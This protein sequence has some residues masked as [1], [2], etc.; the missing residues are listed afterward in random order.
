MELKLEVVLS[1]SI[2]RKKP[3][4]RFCWLGQEKESVFLLDDKRISE[5]NMVS[6]RTKKRTPK[7]HSLL[8]SVVKMASSHN[9]MWLCGLLV[10]GELFLWNRDKDLLKT[11]T[12][13]PEI[14]HMINSAQGD[15]LKL[16]LQVSCDGM[17]VLLA[18]ISGQ[19][20]LWECTEGRYFPGLRDGPVKGR[21]A[22]LLPLEETILPSTKDKEASQHTIFVNTEVMADICLSAF[23]FTSGKQLVVT[24]LKIQWSQGSVRIGSVGYNI[25]WSTKKYPMSHLCPPCQPVKSR[26]AL[27]P[28]F[29]PDGRLLAIVLNQRK[30]KDTQ[31]LFVSTQNFVSVS[32]DLGGCG[33]KKMDIPS[34]YVRSYWVGSVS[35]S[36]EGLFFACVLKRGS[37]LMLARLG[38]LLTLTSSGCN[39]DFGPAQFLPL[40]PLVTYR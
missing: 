5:I 12:G 39:V 31:V 6:G 32:S 21:W 9:G 18:A 20:F 22:H 2:K 37:L 33:S 26:G 40:H 1:S 27:L 30:P 29:S 19:V 8:S 23:V 25:Q 17:R 14:A 11:A 10:S 15:S 7:L 36:A 38:G 24:I 35:W 16:C 3:W 4:P 13:V 34:K 28:A